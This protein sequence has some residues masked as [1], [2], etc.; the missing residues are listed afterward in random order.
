MNT[1]TLLGAAVVTL[2]CA[3]APAFAQTQIPVGVVQVLSGPQSKYG[4]PS[5]RGIALAAEQINAGGGID[6]RPIELFT[7]DSAGKQDQAINAVRKVIGQDHVVVLIGPT[8]STEMFAAS[9]LAND[10]GVP[11]V[12]VTATAA[13]ISAIGDYVFSTALPE[14][15]LI[16][17]SITQANKQHPI[18]RAAILYANDDANM[19]D[20]G[21][22]FRDTSEKQGIE[23]VA[24]EAFG[25]HDTDFSAQL[26]KIASLNVDAIMVS[27]YPD[28]GASILTQARRLGIP[29]SVR[30]IGGNGFNSPKLIDLA[31]AAAEGVIVSG[32][33]SIDKPDPANQAFV[34]AYKAKYNEPPDQFAAQG[35]D[36]MRI[37]AEAL[38]HAPQQDR[39]SIRDALTKVDTTGVLGPF[40]FD[41]ERKAATSEGAITFEVVDGKFQ[42]LR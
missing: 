27:A 16:P 34:A 17:A 11:D 40:R 9:R 13:G 23:V 37:V 10:R 22:I 20:G 33:W 32:P 42:I 7:E 15:K 35:F 4:I 12:G 25:S 6:G 1:R 39:A 21:A 30:F 36:G 8:L 14:A 28:T 41:A 3:G 24:F 38:R 29:E 2:L 19:K 5:Q 26:T 31:G 18:H